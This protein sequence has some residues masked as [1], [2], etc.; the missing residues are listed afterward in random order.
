MEIIDNMSK[1]QG[2]YLTWITP[3]PMLRSKSFYST[4][5]PPVKWGYLSCVCVCVCVCVYGTGAWSQG[6]HLEP[7]HHSF[8]VM[9][10]FQD[11]VSQTICLGRLWTMILQI[12]ASWVAK[13]TGVSHQRLACFSS[14]YVLNLASIFQCAIKDHYPDK[15]ISLT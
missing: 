4:R 5:L 6:L 3:F 12:S 14:Y 1:N 8:F 15:L 7:L 11:K 9:G 10:F 2:Q 13:I